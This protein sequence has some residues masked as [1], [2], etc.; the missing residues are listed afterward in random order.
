MTDNPFAA[1]MERRGETLTATPA[2]TNPFAAEMARR[3]ETLTETPTQSRWLLDAF[4]NVT[5][6]GGR[7]VALD[8]TAATRQAQKQRETALRNTLGESYDPSGTFQ[9]QSLPGAGVAFDLGRSESMEAKTE[10]FRRYYPDG[11]LRSIDTPSGA[12]LVA[13]ESQ[14]AP[15]RQL[16]SAMSNAASFVSEPVV[17]G[18]LGT[19]GGPVGT[20][21]GTGLGVAAQQAVEGARGYPG[22]SIGETGGRAAVEGVLAGALD[23]ATRGASRVLGLTGRAPGRQD[24]VRAASEEGLEP[25]AVGQV[26]DSPAVRDTLSQVRKTA[27]LVEAKLSAQERSLLEAFKRQSL[28]RDPQ[29]RAQL[30]A[31]IGDEQ[32]GALSAA[33]RKELDAIINMSSSRRVDIGQ[34][35]Q[36]GIDAYAVTQREAID[37]AYKEA[38]DLSPDVTFNIAP[39]KGLAREIDEGIVAQGTPR[40]VDTGILDSSGRPISREAPTDVS[41][42][43]PLRTELQRVVDDI[44][45]ITDNVA[46]YKGNTAYEQLKALRTRLF[47]LKEVPPGQL[48]DS[49]H[50][51][52]AR[53][54]GEL[55]EI[56]KNPTGGNPNFVRLWREASDQYRTFA[57]TMEKSFIVRA[58]KTDTPENLSRMFVNPGNFEAVK[59]LRSMVPQPQWQ[60]IKESAKSDILLDPNGLSRFERFARQDPKTLNLLFSRNE[61]SAMKGYLQAA[62]RWEDNVI[63]DLAARNLT[64]GERILT[65]LRSGSAQDI[66]DIVRLSG[67]QNSPM[68]DSMRAGVF[69]DILDRATSLD[70]MGREVLDPNVVVGLIQSYRQGGKLDGLFRQSDWRR[71]LNFQRYAHVLTESADIGGGMMAGS[72]RQQAIELPA[73]LLTGGASP[74]KAGHI[75]RKLMSNKAVAWA[76]TR[77]AIY[78]N[79]PKDTAELTVNTIRR[80]AITS[81][82]AARDLERKKDALSAE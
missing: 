35:L 58:V 34:A 49:Q 26:S 42:S 74:A 48:R 36:E 9:F 11:E 25:L 79:L 19:F 7:R 54:Y 50:A 31:E 44:N 63:S 53:L 60:Q 69:Q 1:E 80:L 37:R 72:L 17:G 15:F 22:P 27:P 66:T 39:L 51:A 23:A 14:D 76:L 12:V 67:G 5:P 61:Q 70:V 8:A 65:T 4:A 59:T 71:L 57:D 13:R 30:L 82:I 41:A 29:T 73:Q 45:A 64:N 10:K 52:A 43:G 38:L 47:D 75:Y 62:A 16:G 18:V 6:G 40:R 2:E 68:A 3:G 24:A 20:A 55:T 21:I 28:D 32:L 56:I 46:D 81:Q 77:P 33:A 78:N